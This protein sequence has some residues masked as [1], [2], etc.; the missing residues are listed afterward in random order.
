MGFGAG[1]AQF[2]WEIMRLGGKKRTKTGFGVGAVKFYEGI[3][4]C[5]NNNKW[6]LSRL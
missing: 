6:I 2:Y 3:M 5:K 4:C 1:A